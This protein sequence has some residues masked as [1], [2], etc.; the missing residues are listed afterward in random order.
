[1]T[2]INEISREYITYQYP[3]YQDMPKLKKNVY[4]KE[5]TI[6]LENLK[7]ITI[8]KMYYQSL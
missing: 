2:D 3:L 5:N 7:Q 8:Y 6:L 1:M 4:T